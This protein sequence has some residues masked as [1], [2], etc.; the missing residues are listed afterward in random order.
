MPSQNRMVSPS[1]GCSWR[2]QNQRIQK[3]YLPRRQNFNTFWRPDWSDLRDWRKTCPKESPEKRNKKHNLWNDK[4]NYTK[5]QPQLNHR[6]V[7]TFKRTFTNNVTPPKIFC[8]QQKYK[9]KNKTSTTAC[10]PVYLYD[11]TCSYSKSCRSGGKRPRTRVDEMLR[12]LLSNSSH[13]K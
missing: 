6:S 4:K 5:T 8:S 1:Y 3:R 13:K 9:T 2:K 10:I 12:V 7:L 11:S